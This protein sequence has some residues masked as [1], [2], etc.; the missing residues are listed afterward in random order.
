MFAFRDLIDLLTLVLECNVV[1]FNGSLYLQTW[2]TS[3]GAACSPIYADLFMSELETTFLK[4]SGKKFKDN[5]YRGFMRRFLDDIVILWKGPKERLEEFM[6]CLNNFHQTV[7]FTCCL[8]DFNKKTAV[9]LDTT[10]VI[11]EGVNAH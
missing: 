7:K 5:I 6:C 10:I 3:M 4:T 9:F 11:E 2:G 8:D 1:E